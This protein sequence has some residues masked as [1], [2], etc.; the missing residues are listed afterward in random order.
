M[1]FTIKDENGILTGIIEGRLDTLNAAQFEQEITPLKEEAGREIV[2]DC[3]KLEYISS[4]GLRVFLSLLK[5][6][7]AKGGKLT[8][9]YI[10]DE[11]KG[12][13]TITGFFKLFNFKS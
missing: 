10:N 2:L 7:N 11:L 1:N 3:T 4:S 9:A 5:E 6:V 12:I 13:F 8:L